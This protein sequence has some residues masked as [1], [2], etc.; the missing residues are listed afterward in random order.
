MLHILHAGD[1]HLDSPFRALSGEQAAQRRQE[2]RALLRSLGEAAREAD[3][4]FL[5]GDLFDSQTDYGETREAVEALLEQIA[6]PTF[7]C[8]GNHDYYAPES[9]WQT[10]RLPEQ[11]RL[12]TEDRLTPVALPELGCTVWGAAFR[13]P[14]SRGFLR[15]FHA[16][17][18][19]GLQ[20]ML[21]HGE[22]T[23]GESPYAPIREWEIRDSG[24]H[25]LAL[26]HVHTCSGLRRSGNTGWAYPGCLMGRGY[27]ECGDKGYL[28]VMVDETHC[29]AEFRPLPGRRYLDLQAEVGGGDPLEA[30]LRVLPPE[31]S[32]DILR[33][34]LTG[35]AASAPE[36]GRIRE[37]LSGRCFGLELRDETRLQQ[38]I[39][40][41]AEEDT[42]RGG[43]LR[44]LK[45]RYD[46]ADEDA[47]A[48]LTLAAR[49]GLAAL[50]GREDLAWN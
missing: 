32:R 17:Q 30:V 19:E 45:E 25:Y 38:D 14:R 16:P 7:L 21:L 37:A 33:I 13:S 15:D 9:P 40:A 12:F 48:Q 43:F 8:P 39:W 50:D 3:L 35:E 29:E 47:R 31:L 1:F 20:L 42:L 49:F 18:G 36:L 41:L 26:G 6:C 2:Q 4:C 22:V 10:L 46:K 44:L 27:D 11:A 23:A 24:L 5:T 34:T 28:W